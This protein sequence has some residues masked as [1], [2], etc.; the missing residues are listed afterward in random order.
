MQKLFSSGR[1]SRTEEVEKEANEKQEFSRLPW[2]TRSKRTTNTISLRNLNIYL[3]YF[4]IYR[5][6]CILNV[7]QHEFDS[8]TLLTWFFSSLLALRLFS[9]DIVYTTQPHHE[10]HATWSALKL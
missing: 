8:S 2:I 7:L 10:Y 3:F 1:K 4:T 5:G 6:R 9:V